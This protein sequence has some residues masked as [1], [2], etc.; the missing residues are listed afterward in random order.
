M[1]DHSRAVTVAAVSTVAL[2]TSACATSPAPTTRSSTGTTPQ[3]TP[4]AVFA[5]GVTALPGGAHALRVA[6]V[7]SIY[8]VVVPA[9]W[10]AL[11]TDLVDKYPETGKR[12]PVLGLSVWDVGQVPRDPCHWQGK[13][14]DPGPSVETLVAALVAEK[15]RNATSP[16][17]VTLAGYEGKY[18]EWSVPADMM[19]STW[20]DFD[21][22]DLSSDGVDRD[23]VSWFANDP[24]HDERYEEVPGQ[25][26]RL[27][28][29]AVNGQR[30]VVD[31]T[32]SP[33]TTQADRAALSRVVDTLRFSA[34]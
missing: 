21:G 25:V 14:L 34:S 2:L 9:G 11:G 31:A 10:F 20:T 30:L 32:Y 18:F 13:G 28:V 17:D 24:T 15:M 23:F 4:I 7:N 33:D 29:L 26:D 8:T 19:S 22:C 16:T 5:P 1:R 6:G 3:P 27:W 12:R